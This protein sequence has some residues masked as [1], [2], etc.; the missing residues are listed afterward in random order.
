MKAAYKIQKKHITCGPI[1]QVVCTGLFEYEEG[2]AITKISFIIMKKYAHSIISLLDKN[3]E[4][5]TIMSIICNLVQALEF[6][7]KTGH[8]YND[9]KVDNM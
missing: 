3:R 7:H 2:E 1:P 9:L 8:V 4:P 5:T 6:V